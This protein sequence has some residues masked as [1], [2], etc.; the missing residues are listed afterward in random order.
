MKQ[1]VQPCFVYLTA[2]VSYPCEALCCCL[3]VHVSYPAVSLRGQNNEPKVVSR[4]F[5]SMIQLLL[6][7]KLYAAFIS[8]L[9]VECMEQHAG[10]KGVQDIGI[11]DW[12]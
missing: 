3:S 7:S 6:K 12:M 5:T 4:T 1:L 11:R 10:N 8:N 2:G 9:A